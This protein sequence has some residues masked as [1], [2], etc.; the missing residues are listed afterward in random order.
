MRRMCVCLATAAALLAASC[1]QQQERPET[2]A[3]RRAA[4]QLRRDNQQIADRAQ[5]TSSML[6]VTTF[7]LVI[8]GCGLGGALF[9]LR[10]TSRRRR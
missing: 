10:W 8:T 9:V 7:A 6:N 1:Q 5:V 4:E 2:T 3:Y